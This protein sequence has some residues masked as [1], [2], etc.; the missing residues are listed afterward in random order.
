ML[1]LPLY[2][3]GTSDVPP[4]LLVVTPVHVIVTSH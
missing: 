1:L 4:V 3:T 2:V